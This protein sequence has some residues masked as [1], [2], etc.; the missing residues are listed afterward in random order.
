[1]NNTPKPEIMATRNSLLAIGTGLLLL[2]PLVLG[3]QSKQQQD[4]F[5][6]GIKGGATYSTIDRIRETLI[7]PIYPDD[8]YTTAE[9]YRPGGLAGLYFDYRFYRSAVAT[10][11]EITYAMLG[12]DFE[13]QDNRDLEYRMQFR[14]DYI[15]ISPMVK[16]NLVAGSLYV[17]GGA[18]FGINLS[19]EKIT[20][21][22][23]M[24]E[25]VPDLQIQTSLREV[26]KGQSNVAA[27]LGLGVEL[28]DSRLHLEARYSYGFKDVMETLPNSYYFAE[29]R[30][31]MSYAQVSVGWSI[32][33]Y[34]TY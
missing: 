4:G 18:E 22:S 21:T 8:T 32:P 2:I 24:S 6:W 9:A 34:E 31:R 13:Y 7:S 23:N 15:N 28:L 33:F 30:N 14:Y 16:L 17:I 25:T 20:Y 10:R 3:A 27:T 26:L 5:Y 11:V 12:G 1:M 19:G 29:M